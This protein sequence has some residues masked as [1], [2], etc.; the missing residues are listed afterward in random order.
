MKTYHIKTYLFPSDLVA[1]KSN[2]KEQSEVR[3]FDINYEKSGDNYKKFIDH[4]RTVYEGVIRPSDIIKTYWIDDEKDLVCFSTEQEFDVA[5]KE[6]Y[7]F[8]WFK[9]YIFFDEPKS[10]WFF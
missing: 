10:S 5:L 4:I 6:I 1:K 2:L 8:N 9:V 7:S 3:K